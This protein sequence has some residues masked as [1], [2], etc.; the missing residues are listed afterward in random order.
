MIRASH[1]EDVETLTRRGA[2]IEWT[3]LSMAV[4]RYCQDRILRHGNTTVVF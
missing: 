2:D 4:E 3:V 1:R